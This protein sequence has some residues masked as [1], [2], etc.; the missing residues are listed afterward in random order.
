MAKYAIFCLNPLTERGV[1]PEFTIDAEA[2][3]A[4]GLTVLTFDHDVLERRLDARAALRSM[5]ATEPG[6]VVY[7]GWMLRLEAYRVLFDELASRGFTLITDPEAYAACHHAPGSY[8]ALKAWMPKTRWVEREH[9]DDPAAI[10]AAME[11]FGHRPVILKDWVKSQAGY[12]REACFIPDASDKVQVGRVV[13][14]FRELQ[15][16]SLVGGLVFKA[17][18]TLMPGCGPPHEFRAFILDG[19][20]VGCWPRD[21]TSGEP[22]PPDLVALVAGHIPSRFASA[23]FAIDTRGRWWL[24]EVGDGQVSGLPRPDVAIP[25]LHALASRLAG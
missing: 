4:A 11:A 25:L 18:Q 2:A 5:R 14:R 8:Q 9:M 10:A 21:E 16:D 15:D 20:V 24:L 23:D 3:R 22:P 17:Y 12:W 13:S 6:E 7:R 1:D 19:V